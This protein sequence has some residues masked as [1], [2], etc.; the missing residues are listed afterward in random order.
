MTTALTGRVKSIH[1]IS[2]VGI[3]ENDENGYECRE[4]RNRERKDCTTGLCLNTDETRADDDKY[5]NRDED[6]YDDKT[7]NGTRQRTN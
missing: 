4:L 1:E 6:K 7:R 2:W 5:D 3:E